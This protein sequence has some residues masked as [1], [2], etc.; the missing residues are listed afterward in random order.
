MEFLLNPAKQYWK[1]FQKQHPKVAFLISMVILILVILGIIIPLLP[2][3]HK[4][5]ISNDS[6]KMTNPPDLRDFIIIN[7]DNNPVQ[8][9]E[10][11]NITNTTI[12]IDIP[13]E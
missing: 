9:T 5:H 6:E 4:S 13:S 8:K 1:K 11:G 3:I 7:G 2:L 12:K 10:N